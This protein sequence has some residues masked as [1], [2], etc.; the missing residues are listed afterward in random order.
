[1]SYPSLNWSHDF[2]LWG[3]TGF[4]MILPLGFF[5]WGVGYFCKSF[6]NEKIRGV[7]PLPRG[8]IPEEGVREGDSKPQIYKCLP[9]WVEKN[10]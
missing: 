1:L 7:Y 8:I 6:G 4:L 9:Q 10:K 3:L 2:F 5:F